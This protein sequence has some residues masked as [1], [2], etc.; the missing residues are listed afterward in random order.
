MRY[1]KPEKMNMVA[2]EGKSREYY[3]NVSF[4]SEQLPEAK[5]WKVGEEHVVTM[6]LR[7]KSVN[8]NEDSKG[9][10]GFEVR[11]MSLAKKE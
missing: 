3:P 11:K 2:S 8:D 5:D 9:S 1:V 6:T 7:M 4:N 10:F